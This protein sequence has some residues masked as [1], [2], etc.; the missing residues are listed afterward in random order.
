MYC[1]FFTF[2]ASH[3]ECRQA[4]A[5]KNNVLEMR[6]NPTLIHATKKDQSYVTT[7]SSLST[8]TSAIYSVS[9]YET[10]SL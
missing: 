2:C 7:V 8:Y 3:S 6:E 5:L 9:Q 10:V 1:T 4:A